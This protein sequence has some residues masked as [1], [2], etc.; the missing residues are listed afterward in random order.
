MLLLKLLFWGTVIAAIAFAIWK[1]VP[2]DDIG[3]DPDEHRRP[4]AP[5]MPSASANPIPTFDQALPPQT[6]P[7]GPKGPGN[8]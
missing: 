1:L 7:T 2:H 5:T 6:P 4:T 8:P 3:R